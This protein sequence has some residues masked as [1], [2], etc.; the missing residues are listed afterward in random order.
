[1]KQLYYMGQSCVRKKHFF[2][3]QTN[4]YNLTAKEVRKARKMGF[5]ADEYMIYGLKHNDPA[6]YVS[7]YEREI[8][9]EA[10]KEYRILL[11]NKV[12]F[13]NLIR[14]FAPTNQIFSYK[15]KGVYCA[16]ETGYE[17]ENLVHKLKELGKLVYKVP[18]AGGGEGFHL[19]EYVE[20]NY[21]VDRQS[22][23]ED[24]ILSLLNRDDYLIEEYCYQGSFENELWEYSVNTIRIITIDFE[25]DIQVPAAIQRIGCQLN[26]CVD[27]ASAG[28]LFAEIDVDSGKLSAARS[29]ST[30]F[31]RPD[32]GV[33]QV[34]AFHPIKGSQIEGLLIPNWK[35]LRE[36]IIALHQKLSFTGI[37]F[38]AWDIALGDDGYK[39]IEANTSCGM[40]FLQTKSG[41]RSSSIGLWMKKK[42]YIQ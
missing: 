35:K 38:Y 23:E 9:R 22:V 19:L 42:G 16:L 31:F 12:V 24:V 25:G 14:N 29:Y 34:F 33:E 41:V 36:D 10:A 17:E 18:N 15:M 27:N 2:A 4:T 5:T 37:D 21:Y 28:G 39:V 40:K 3:R 32:N 8:F 11:D 6:E 1:M 30:E 20:A 13:Y 26:R 7:E